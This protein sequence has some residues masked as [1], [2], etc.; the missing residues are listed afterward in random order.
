MRIVRGLALSLVGVVCA[1]VLASCTGDQRPAPDHHQ[2]LR[3]LA[4]QLGADQVEA[5]RR[6]L[7][8]YLVRA[9]EDARMHYNLACLEA[10]AGDREA[11][12]AEL[13]LA[14]RHG[15]RRLD[16]VRADA[17]LAPLR[18]DDHLE[19]LLTAH[20][21]SLAEV[22][23][24]A[25]IHLTGDAWSDATELG[26]GTDLR[27]RQTADA[28]QLEITGLP[29]V[30][31]AWVV[32][33]VPVD[34][35]AWETPR[36]FEF[37]LT[38]AETGLAVTPAPAEVDGETFTIPWSA[39]EPHR[40]PLDLLLGLNVVVATDDDRHALVHDPWLGR[41]D[42]AWRR[43]A[44]LHLEPGDDACAVLAARPDT[45]LAIGDSLS[46]ELGLQGVPDGEVAVT[47]TAERAA[48][49]GGRRAR[50]LR[51]RLR[52]AP[53]CASTLRPPAG[54]ARRGRADAHDLVWHIGCSAF[55]PA[56]SWRG[57]SVWPTARG[58]AAHRAL[59]D[60]P[61][62]ARPADVRPP[63]RSGAA[64]RGRRGTDSLL[65]RCDRT[66]SVFS[67]RRG[68]TPCPWPCGQ[69]GRAHGRA[70]GAAA[71]RRARRC[72]RK[73]MLVLVAD[74]VHGERR[75]RHA[76]GQHGPPWCWRCRQ[77]RGA[78]AATSEKP[79]RGAALAGRGCRR[80]RRWP[81]TAAGRAATSA[82][83]T[84]A[85]EPAAVV[86]EATLWAD[87]HVDP[88]PLPE[89]TRSPRGCHASLAS[90][91]TEVVLPPARG[92]TRRGHRGGPRRRGAWG[93]SGDDVAVWLA[94]ARER[95]D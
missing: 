43:Y 40:P 17:D 85:A 86:V 10:R 46:L 65:A 60:V 34:H 19:R 32:V 2:A 71:G 94:R 8:D 21:D 81:S 73:A 38:A 1:V 27:V 63:R 57:S 26:P 67:A 83:L 80:S 56:G 82:V 30:A 24:A 70:P 23:R 31:R 58:R 55:G 78:D 44:P 75:R 61:R 95:S 47:V 59:L 77:R 16:S 45:G 14:L 72:P 36:W 7:R 33:A 41:S 93:A 52:H 20:A 64:R 13:R 89:P 22:A 6:D 3:R 51:P 28:L 91:T 48:P 18:T 29:A 37:A 84:A 76:G 12:L 9:P 92:A 49:G 79:L 4:A 25:A 50:G 54:S 74:E 11:A 87:A 68:G 42:G 66:G 88:W 15:Y 90:L 35:D 62:A 39:L 53:S 69:A 5:A